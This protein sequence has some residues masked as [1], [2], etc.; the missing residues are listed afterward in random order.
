VGSSAWRAR[1][2][3]EN[4]LQELKPMLQILWHAPTTDQFK[5]DLKLFTM[6]WFRKDANYAQ[7]FHNT[8]VKRYLPHTWAFFGR[9]GNYPTGNQLLE[10]W[11]NRLKDSIPRANLRLDQFVDLLYKEWCYYESTINDAQ[12]LDEQLKFLAQRKREW[13]RKRN[14]TEGTMATYL[15]TAHSITSF[16]NLP[17]SA[18]PVIEE[19]NTLDESALSG[20]EEDG[21]SQTQISQVE[22]ESDSETSSALVSVSTS[23][24]RGQADTG[25]TSTERGQ[26]VT[27]ST[28]KRNSRPRKTATPQDSQEEESDSDTTRALVSVST[29]TK[30]GQADTGSTSTKTGT[31]SKTSTTRSVTCKLC[32]SKAAQKCTNKLCQSCCAVS[33]SACTLTT[34]NRAKGKHRPADFRQNLHEAIVKQKTVTIVYNGGSNPG[35]A[36]DVQLIRWEKRDE[37]LKRLIS[38]KNK[39]NRIWCS[40]WCLLRKQVKVL[41]G[42]ILTIR[43]FYSVIGIEF[44]TSFYISFWHQ[45]LCV[46]NYL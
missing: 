46:F 38:P 33:E 4:L 2:E 18:G 44:S 31:P 32:G 12:L 27:P 11:H 24:K 16:T 17:I 10:G 45:L 19:I 14:T 15:L 40:A 36:R 26:T 5:Q 1:Q 39:T 41:P 29:S 28:T 34:H 6:Y 35:T 42:L 22:D 30:R 20:I 9:K 25:S 8:W 21:E 7:Y 3:T 13:T 23:T 37:N 43:D